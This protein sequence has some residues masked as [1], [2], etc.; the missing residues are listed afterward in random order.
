MVLDY[1]NSLFTTMELALKFVL[2]KL[3]DR[4]DHVRFGAVCKS[5]HSIVK[6][7]HQDNPFMTNVPMLMI[8]TK[9]RS[10]TK[11]SLY[12]IPARKVYPFQLFVPYNKRCCGYSHGWIATVDDNNVMSPKSF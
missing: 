1:S 8:P 3:E 12:S 11:R 4:I 10:R 7:Y 6:L 9:R 5:W 2:D